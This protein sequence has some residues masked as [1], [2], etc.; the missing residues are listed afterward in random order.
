MIGNAQ[1]KLNKVQKT[2]TQHSKAEK[3]P[4]VPLEELMNYVE[5]PPFPGCLKRTKKQTT[6]LVVMYIVYI[7]GAAKALSCAVVA[8]IR[9]CGL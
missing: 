4:S 5:V 8:L 1:K 7:I 6:Q 3:A 2:I 9:S